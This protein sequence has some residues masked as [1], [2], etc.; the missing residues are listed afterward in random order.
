MSLRFGPEASEASSRSAVVTTP[1]QVETSLGPK[2]SSSPPNGASSTP[3]EAFHLL[4]V[5]PQ[6][7]VTAFLKQR[8]RFGGPC[9]DIQSIAMSDP[10][11]GY[12]IDQ[13]A[14]AVGV[15]RRT[16]RLWVARR[17]LS[18][19]RSRGPGARYAADSM[20]R[21]RVIAKLRHDGW[22]LDQIAHEIAH[23]TPEQLASLLPPP[24]PVSPAPPLAAP[25]PD[26]GNASPPPPSPPSYPA[27]RWE[28]VVL[29]PGLELH[30]DL[31][32]GQALQRVAHE[33]YRHYGP[34]AGDSTR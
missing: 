11:P 33:I 7:S 26:A 9:A 32:A 4:R 31:S 19:P 16:I 18:P 14:G 2:A 1:T 15:Q 34:A 10:E 27:A 20:L 8:W 28:R 6:E 24:A 25:A 22:L 21:V 29:V 30:V 17:L 5:A 13:L 23:A 3:V 12:T